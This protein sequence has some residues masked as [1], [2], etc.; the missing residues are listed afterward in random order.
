[1]DHNFII[2]TLK[3]MSIIYDFTYNSALIKH[4]DIWLFIRVYIYIHIC[5]HIMYSLFI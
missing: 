4:Y 1:M 3:Y 2:M 5:I